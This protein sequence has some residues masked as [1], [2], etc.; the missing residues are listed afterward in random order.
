MSAALSI[1]GLRKVYKNGVEALKKVDLEVPQGDFFALLGPNGAGKTTIIGTVTGLIY[2]TEGKVSVFGEDIDISPEKARTYIGVVPQEL[3]FNIF[4][5]PLDIVVN[6]AGYY[7][8]PRS[9]ALPRAESLLKALDLYGKKDE[10]SMTLSGGMKR[11]LMIA[12]ALVHE[13]RFL[14][15]EQPTA[16]V[17]VELRRSIWDYLKTLTA[18]GISILLTTHYLEEAEQLCKHVAIINKGDIIASG[19]MKDILGRLKT[20][21]IIVDLTKPLTASALADLAAYSPRKVD[22]TSIEIEIGDGLGL[23]D[24][25]LSLNRNGLP[26]EAIRG[27]SSRL[28]E[29]FVHLT[30]NN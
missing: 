29:V 3:N 13:P 19:T 15:L 4:E 21:K 24:A 2:K 1:K 12:R 9:V 10:K 20:E 25:I 5:K 18:E 11:R 16:G 7:G 27:K 8:I 14:I 6:Q 17:E 22:D 30:K 26:I 28:E 23:N